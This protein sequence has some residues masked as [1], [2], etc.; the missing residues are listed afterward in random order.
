MSESLLNDLREEELIYDWNRTDDRQA[1]APPPRIIDHSLASFRL[2]PALGAVSLESQSEIL[3]L[4]QQIGLEHL[5][6]GSWLDPEVQSL[7][8]Q[9]AT[10]AGLAWLEAPTG[11]L[12]PQKFGLYLSDR[13]PDWQARLRRSQ[14]PVVLVLQ[15]A[16]GR[17]PEQLCTTLKSLRGT[18]LRGICLSDDRGQALPGGAQQLVT[19][20]RQ[21]LERLEMDL[22]IEWSG[23]NDR[24]LALAS[25]L[26][27][28]Q[29]GAR[30][31]HSAFFGLGEG[32]GLVATE[33]LLVNLQ[34]WGSLRRDLKALGQVSQ[35]LAQRFGVEIPPNSPIVGHDA[36]R[37]G[38]GVHAAAIVKAQKKGHDWLADLIYSGVPANQFGFHQQ[39]EVGPMAG[40]SNIHFWLDQR[41]LEK[42]P[43][44]VQTLLAAAKQSQRV[45]S[46]EQM[47]ALVKQADREG[48]GS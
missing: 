14:G 39:V 21:A 47:L 30:G 18:R 25:A 3:G 7:A 4:L 44:R 46:E 33:Q 11:S 40:A 41:G 20:V 23:R 27:A 45:L 19:F 34:L 32:S 24:G 9:E 10:W 28:W 26:A 12:P 8:Q 31:L 29:A 15:D 13:D 17:S 48:D 36:F 42:S 35:S 16:T 22:E 37:T 1:V 38:T 6:L 2:T 43:N 5:C